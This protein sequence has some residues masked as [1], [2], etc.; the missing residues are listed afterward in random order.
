MWDLLSA[1]VKG[2]ALLRCR[3]AA[4]R[5]AFIRPNKYMTPQDLKLLGATSLP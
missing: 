4:L 1:E 3:H 5:L 2:T